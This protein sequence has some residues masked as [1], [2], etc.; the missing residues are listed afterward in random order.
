MAGRIQKDL[1]TVHNAI[2]VT[3]SDSTVLPPGVRALWIGVAGDV[4]V[5]FAATGDIVT[6][7]NVPAGRHLVQ[8]SQ[9]LAATTAENILA[10]Y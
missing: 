6:Y 2:D 9:V 3:P 7:T 5:R 10:E 4:R 1:S 8:V